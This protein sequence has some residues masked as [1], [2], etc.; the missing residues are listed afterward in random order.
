MTTALVLMTVAPKASGEV[1]EALKA[2]DAVKEAGALFG[3]EDVYA[4]VDVSSMEELHVLVMGRIQGIGPVSTT[5][6]YIV[7][8]DMKWSR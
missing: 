1:V 3:D 2:I 5:K 6:T 8:S 7:I 4:K